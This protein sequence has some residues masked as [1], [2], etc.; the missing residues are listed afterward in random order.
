MAKNPN[1]PFDGQPERNNR[2]YVPAS[3]ANLGGGGG[4][5]KLGGGYE[6]SKTDGQIATRGINRKDQRYALDETEL[7]SR[8]QTRANAEAAT[9]VVLQGAMGFI[10]LRSQSGNNYDLDDTGNGCDCPDKWRLFESG[11]AS[12]NC[13]HELIAQMALSNVGGY[14]NL[15]WSTG[16]LAEAIGIDERTAQ[17]LCFDGKVPATKV[18]GIWTITYDTTVQTAIDDYRATMVM[19]DAPSVTIV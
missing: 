6:Q 3:W 16:R 17:R 2:E 13:K 5:P 11:K 14:T 7:Q 12:V 8:R 10:D 4:A 19:P 15:P 18:H 1:Q 9:T